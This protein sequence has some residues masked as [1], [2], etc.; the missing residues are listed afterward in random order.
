ML[1]Y[2]LY[3]CTQAEQKT[4]HLTLT[5]FNGKL[6]Y[7]HNNHLHPCTLCSLAAYL[8]LKVLKRSVGCYKSVCMRPS[9]WDPVKFTC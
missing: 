2:H 7:S 1:G 8:K 6:K 4:L 5:H 3:S 9:H